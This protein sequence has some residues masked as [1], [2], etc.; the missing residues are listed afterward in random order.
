MTAFVISV[1]YKHHQQ[2]SPPPSAKLR[3]LLKKGKM[4]KYTNMVIFGMVSRF[5][6]EMSFSD[7]KWR[8]IKLEEVP[9]IHFVPTE[10]AGRDFV[11]ML[12]YNLT[13]K[14]T[15]LPT[16]KCS[17]GLGTP[18]TPSLGGKASEN[19]FLLSRS[20]TPKTSLRRS[21]PSWLLKGPFRPCGPI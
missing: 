7:C 4:E 13:E 20:R 1:I 3:G 19:I 15:Q 10:P 14:K 11:L 2:P 12:I 8:R 5:S 21:L 6:A 17:I 18:K 9:L 16:C